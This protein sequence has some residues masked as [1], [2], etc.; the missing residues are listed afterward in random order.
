LVTRIGDRLAAFQPPFLVVD[1]VL[2]DHRGRAMFPDGV[3][4]AYRETL[5]PLANLVTPNR[6]ET[7]LLAGRSVDD[8]DDLIEAA[9]A[10]LA[11]GAPYVLA[12]GYRQGDEMVDVLV[13]A[14]RPRFFRHPAIET[15]NTHGS[16]DTLS[17]AICVYLAQGWG[18]AAAV[19]AALEFTQQ[20]IR[21]AAG[22]R[23]GLGHG[24]VSHF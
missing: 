4:R 13:G 18:M 20:A 12:K 9:Q 17:A 7:A 1:P 23:L 19:E 14:D 24:P 2:V 15:A 5:L 3:T 6:E 10:I 21:R 8:L 11:L 22:W 16:G